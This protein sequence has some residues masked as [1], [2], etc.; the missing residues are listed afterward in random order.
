MYISR[1]LTQSIHSGHNGVLCDAVSRIDN[2][3]RYTARKYIFLLP[4]ARSLL[5]FPCRE[6]VPVFSRIVKC[7]SP[8][9][10]SPLLFSSAF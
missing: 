4:L 8:P 6:A 3:T 5:S 7:I 9:L 1:T 10:H 2:Q